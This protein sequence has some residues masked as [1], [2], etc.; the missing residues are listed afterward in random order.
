VKLE[1]DDNVDLNLDFEYTVDEPVADKFEHTFTADV[2][3]GE[4]AEVIDQIAPNLPGGRT[5]SNVSIGD[6]KMKTTFAATAS[7]TMVTDMS[8]DGKFVFTADVSLLPQC[9][10]PKGDMGLALI[11]EFS[12]EISIDTSNP[13]CWS[14]DDD[15]GWAKSDR[16]GIQNEC[17]AWSARSC[18]LEG[19]LQALNISVGEE[20]KPDELRITVNRPNG[21]GAEDWFG[22]ALS[23][24][25]S[26]DVKELVNDIAGDIG[27]GFNS[28]S[29]TSG[30]TATYGIEVA[31][32][33]NEVM[34]IVNETRNNKGGEHVELNVSMGGMHLGTLNSN[35]EDM[36]GI[37][38]LSSQIVM[39]PKLGKEMTEMNQDFQIL[40]QS[41][42]GDGMEGFQVESKVWMGPNMTETLHISAKGTDK[43]GMYTLEGTGALMGQKRGSIDI[44]MKDDTGTLTVDLLSDSDTKLVDLDFT[45][46]EDDETISFSSQLEANGQ[47]MGDISGALS[48]DGTAMKAQVSLKDAAGN[49]ASSV[50]LELTEG[51]NENTLTAELVLPLEEGQ[52]PVKLALTSKASSANDDNDHKF[53]C[54]MK[55][56]GT[57]LLDAEASFI[58]ANGKGT[59]DATVDMMTGES[60]EEVFNLGGVLNKEKDV[61][62]GEATLT[63]P[64]LADGQNF[65]Q[66]IQAEVSDGLQDVVKNGLPGFKRMDIAAST[67]WNSIGIEA[68]V[69]WEFPPYNDTLSGLGATVNIMQM[70]EEGKMKELSSTAVDMEFPFSLAGAKVVKEVVTVV[71]MEIE[72]EDVTQFNEEAFKAELAKVADSD[73]KDVVI[74]K[75]EFLVK[76]EYSFSAE[77]TED[78]VVAAIAE[79]AG[80]D[81]DRVT[82]AITTAR[83]LSAASESHARR[84][85]GINVEAEIK[86]EKAGEVAAIKEA[87]EDEAAL[88]EAVK[89]VANVEVVAQV[90]K[91]PKTVV[92]VVTKVK[93]NPLPSPADSGSSDS[94]AAAPTL[95]FSSEDLAGMGEAAGGTVEVKEIKRTVE[96][97][98]ETVP[99]PAPAPE[100]VT[101][102]A[103]SQRDGIVNLATM[104]Q[105]ACSVVCILLSMVRIM[106][107]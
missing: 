47:K 70:G 51:E 82:V 5:P 16:D 55:Q 4:H 80:V 96:Y 90:T 15:D 31:V 91:A 12:S 56:A 17:K 7:A 37:F 65:T 81:K 32:G 45:M 2:T 78:E 8:Q 102:P 1:V 76:A 75:V 28:T 6:A 41:L 46:T 61:Y 43:S 71:D 79:A 105:P 22:W 40:V 106:L 107:G 62:K 93:T 11:K 86:A 104:P 95:E 59:L 34:M 48:D 67:V 20:W 103:P 24:L 53:E 35:R 73:V 14:C 26:S 13:Q 10:V 25:A 57:T 38:N 64:G 98:T 42:E 9:T 85:A 83:R 100:T 30:G 58:K 84:L 74:E 94:E 77:I 50:D 18:C 27:V 66:K 33:E 52:D 88:V 87:A 23:T 49:V 101:T 69:Y 3:L 68:E 97:R 36:D 72:I 54:T 39:N 89:T 60:L 99:T 63:I 44:S 19:M 21:G 92:Q 29:I